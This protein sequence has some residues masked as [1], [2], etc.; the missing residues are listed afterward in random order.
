MDALAQIEQRI[1]RYVESTPVSAM[2]L[3]I[4]Q[5]GEFI[6]ERGF[7][8]EDVS[9]DTVFPSCSTGKTITATAI[10]RLV[11]DGRLEL[12]RPVTEYVPELRYPEGGDASRVTLRQLLSHTSGL[13]SDP[14]VPDGYRTDP[15]TALAHQVLEEVPHYQAIAPGEALIYSN[16][17]FSIAGY[18]ASLVS[19]KPFPDLVD[20]L[21]LQPLGMTSTS[22]DPSSSLSAEVKSTLREDFLSE[23]LPNGYPAG[24]AVTTVRDLG[25]LAMCYLRGGLD[26]LRPETVELMHSVH[27]DAYCRDPRRYGLG[28]DVESHRGHKLVSHGGGG[29]GCGS[30]FVLCPEQDLAVICLFNHP[31]GYGVRARD[32]LDSLLEWEDEVR[33]A[34]DEV[35]FDGRFRAVFD[36]VSGY[37]REIETS[38]TGGKPYVVIDGNRRRLIPYS[39]GVYVTE[40]NNASVGFVPD[41]PYALLDLA[42]IGLV[43]TLPYRSET[44]DH[45]AL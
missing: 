2:A 20:E 40:D 7:G 25:K 36:N 38:R 5:T 24:G 10:M 37:P 41:G 31:A 44:N 32:I 26:I 8:N 3:A 13:S 30:A 27:A 14:V 29:S 12:D 1:H 19:E 6:F 4:I 35:F 34:I 18:A 23:R 43:S 42:G 28:F 15:A 39:D 33:D 45:G 22:F 21:V 16:P 11:E 17:G 9:P